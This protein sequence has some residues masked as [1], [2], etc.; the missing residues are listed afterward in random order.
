M[1]RG[2]LMMPNVMRRAVVL[3]VLLVV[4][5]AGAWAQPPG[6]GSAGGERPPLT[7]DDLD[8]EDFAGSL[9]N[10]QKF[11]DM[12]VPFLGESVQQLVDRFGPEIRANV[13]ALEAS[14]ATP[15]VRYAA[16]VLGVV[17]LLSGRR[18]RGWSWLAMGAVIGLAVAPLPLIDTLRRELFV[19]ELSFLL[20]DPLATLSVVAVGALAGLMVLAPTFYLGV[21]GIMILVGIALGTQLFGASGDVFDS[22]GLLFGLIGGTVA[23]G[24]LS[25]RSGLLVTL[26][27]GAALITFGL[28]LPPVW[29]VLLM[30][31]GGLLIGVRSPRGRQ[32][33]KRITLPTLELQEGKVAKEKIK[34]KRGEAH[35]HD[36]LPEM[37]DDSGEPLIRR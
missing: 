29:I 22:P 26:A 37:A 9:R 27:I 34:P 19:D 18:A 35:L 5:A 15:I 4:I 10:P 30:A 6:G 21:T 23:G 8:W 28:N 14:V 7:P 24:F 13:T 16:L 2:V 20:D 3:G 25:S 11:I 32:L 36:I 33:T 17:V 12:I 31:V 1:R